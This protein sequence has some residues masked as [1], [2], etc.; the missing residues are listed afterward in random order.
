M[1][2][3]APRAS[4]LQRGDERANDAHKLYI[5]IYKYSTYPFNYDPW[6]ASGSAKS[7]LC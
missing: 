4:D 5:H 6:A 7:Q 3:P 2:H 1:A